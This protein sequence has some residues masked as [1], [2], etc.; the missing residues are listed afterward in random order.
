MHQP[1]VVG[2][3][4]PPQDPQPQGVPLGHGQGVLGAEERVQRRSHDEFHDQRWPAVLCANE[5][6]R[7]HHVLVEDPL[8]RFP[9]GPKPLGAVA[10]DPPRELHR[11]AVAGPSVLGDVDRAHAPRAEGLWEDVVVPESVWGTAHGTS[12][13]FS[14]VSDFV[15]DLLGE[16]DP[17]RKS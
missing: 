14:V 10:I 4:H 6:E 17:Y 3:R 11:E 15:S 16:R 9:F 1:L 8:Q 7:T 12:P 2:R 13:G 5:L